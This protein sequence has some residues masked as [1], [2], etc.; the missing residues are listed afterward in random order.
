M[1]EKEPGKIETLWYGSDGRAVAQMLLRDEE[2]FSG[3]CINSRIGIASVVIGDAKLLGMEICQ[4]N[5]VV[6]APLLPIIQPPSSYQEIFPPC[7]SLSSLTRN[8]F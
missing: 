3:M 1:V 5:I 4:S 7:L 8:V 6:S 2:S